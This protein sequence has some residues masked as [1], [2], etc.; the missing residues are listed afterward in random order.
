MSALVASSALA[1]HGTDAVMAEVPARLARYRTFHTL[2]ALRGVAAITVVLFHAAF[3]YGLV[4]PAAGYLAVDLFFVMSGFIIAHRYED[5]LRKGMSVAGF[6]KVRLIRLYP[7][8]LLGTVLGVVPALVA[9]TTGQGGTFYKGLVG[10][11]PLAV[12]MLPSRLAWPHFGEVYPLN[13][14]SWS[15]ALEVVVN[16]VYALTFRVWTARRLVL[17]LAAAFV[18]L[19]AAATVYGSLDVGFAWS[20]VLGGLPRILYGFGMGVLLFRAHTA[21]P[22]KVRA[23]WWALLVIAVF[24]F[25]FDPRVLGVAWAKP[26]WDVAMVSLV[27]PAIVI[28]ALVN[29]PPKR[30][31]GACAMAGVFSYVVYSLHAPFVG[32]FLRGEER[33]HL[34]TYTTSPAKALVFTFLLTVLCVVAH[35]AYDKPIRRFLSR[36]AKKYGD[37]PRLAWR[38]RTAVKN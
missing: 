9:V 37:A 25:F 13:Y 12:L 28:A 33:L 1:R 36:R 35:L 22:F 6:I 38:T 26:I 32:L 34:D 27:V 5:D 24:V 19:C 14:V 15:L 16:I 11:F 2:D 3:F 7:L 31:Q 23:P 17:L 21:R 10:S 30:A 20:H 29:E 4:P 18:G 8:F